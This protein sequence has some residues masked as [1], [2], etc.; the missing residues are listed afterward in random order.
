[1]MSACVNPIGSA[2]SPIYRTIMWWNKLWSRGIYVQSAEDRIIFS[3]LGPIFLGVEWKWGREDKQDTEMWEIRGSRGPKQRGC[4][5]KGGEKNV[6]IMTDLGI[7]FPSCQGGSTA[8]AA[9][10]AVS[11]WA[12]PQ[13]SAL[14]YPSNGAKEGCETNSRL[15][16][17][18]GRYKEWAEG[19][20]LFFL[21]LFQATTHLPSKSFIPFQILQFKSM[22]SS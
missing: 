5:N 3:D 19:H 4:C 11:P 8:K 15:R 22:F 9:I 10:L 13:S 2:L 21:L 7:C 12:V 6:S 16:K 18:G 20:N 1:M 17:S 14:T